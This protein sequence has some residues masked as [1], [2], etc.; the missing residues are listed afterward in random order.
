MFPTLGP[1]FANYVPFS[2]SIIFLDFEPFFIN[3]VGVD[4]LWSDDGFNVYLQLS[5]FVV[6]SQIPKTNADVQLLANCHYLAI[7]LNL[8]DFEVLVIDVFDNHVFFFQLMLLF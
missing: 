8:D 1:P 3:Y 6:S 5:K 7:L 4:I 2:N